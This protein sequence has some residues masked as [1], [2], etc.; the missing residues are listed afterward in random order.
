M[1]EE[2]TVKIKLMAGAG[3]AA[4]AVCLAGMTAG[5]ASAAN[6]TAPFGRYVPHGDI[7]TDTVIE[8]NGGDSG[9]MPDQSGPSEGDM[10]GGD[11]FSP[12]V[13]APAP[14]ELTEGEVAS[15]GFNAG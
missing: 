12:Q 2:T 1:T 7:A 13:L 14:F 11:K 6:S 10:T 3:V 4:M 8:P 5:V 15:P 9:E